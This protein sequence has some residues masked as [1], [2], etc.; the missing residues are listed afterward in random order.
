MNRKVPKN[1]NT[2]TPLR[3]PIPPPNV[4]PKILFF[5]EGVSTAL[6]TYPCL[7]AADIL[8]YDTNIVPVG[9]DQKQHLELTRDLAMKFN[10]PI[11]RNALLNCP[12]NKKFSAYY[13]VMN[14]ANF[15]NGNAAL[16]KGLSNGVRN[17]LVNEFITSGGK[18]NLNENVSEILIENGQA[19][20]II[21][22]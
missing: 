16:P 20:G 1:D 11:I 5:L 10:S 17:R 18:I 7:M 13:F 12:V 2:N 15:V 4:A 22:R 8:L 3:I 9:E 14:L 6:L 21:S 19:K